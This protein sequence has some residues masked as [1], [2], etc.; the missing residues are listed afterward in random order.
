MTT[1]PE[2]WTTPGIFEVAAGV[3]RLPLPLPND[4]LRA[5]NVYVIVGADELV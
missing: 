2:D 3:Y 1:A 4:G 5:V